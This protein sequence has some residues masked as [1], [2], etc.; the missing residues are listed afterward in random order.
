LSCAIA[1]VVVD[2]VW[3][4]KHGNHSASR[5]FHTT[6][7]PGLAIATLKA[8]Q[9]GTMLKNRKLITTALL[10]ALGFAQGRAFANSPTEQIEQTIQQV[11][12]I[13]ANSTNGD[14]RTKDLLRETLM[15]RFDWLEMS[16]QSLGK[17]WSHASGRENEFVS[18]FAAFLGNAYIGQIGSYRNEKILFV[19]ESIENN[20]A[21]VKTKI[22]SNHGE[23]TAVNYQLRCIDGD[24]KIYD[25]VVE[26]ISIVS[27]Y[28]SQ[29][30]RILAKGSFE[31]L[32]RQ[33]REKELKTR[34]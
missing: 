7:E 9:G 14:D 31:E 1:I 3:C 20:R 17:H 22:V 18:A 29:F 34:N 19:H 10:L 21:Q 27:N 25:V 28:R 32:L 6:F 16:K 2:A 11:A 5:S 30:S 12:N 26:D 23:P 24:W 15:P 13:V 4:V 33:L 8:I